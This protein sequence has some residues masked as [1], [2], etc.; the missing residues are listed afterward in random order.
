MRP[1]AAH[2]AD[3]ERTLVELQTA[4]GAGGFAAL[5]ARGL[6]NR[7]IAHTLYN[8]ERTADTHVEHVFRK[9]GLRSRAQAA[10]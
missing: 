8:F 1:H 5:V 10:A 2:V 7:R 9:L 4:Q 6:T 3:R